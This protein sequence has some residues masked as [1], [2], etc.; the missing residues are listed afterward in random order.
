MADQHIFEYHFFSPRK[1]CTIRYGITSGSRV[2]ASAVLLL[3]QGRAE[4]IEKYQGIARQ[5]QSKGFTV[6][7]FD[8]QGQGLSSRTLE[9][10][11]KGYIQRFDAYVA[12]LEIFYSRVVEP[13]GLP[14]YILAHSMGGHIAL[15]F[16]GRHPSTI[17]KAVLASPMIDLELPVITRQVARFISRRFSGT[18]F[19]EKYVPGS[20]DYSHRQARFKENVLTHDPEKYKILHDEIKKNPDLALGGVT[21]GWLHAAFESIRELKQDKMVRNILVPIL[22][23][24]AQ[25]DRVV[26][27]R[28]Q[29]EFCKRLPDAEFLPIEGAFHELLFEAPAI[30]R[31]V[32]KAFDRFIFG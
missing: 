1:D 8:W 23:I 24:S 19:A 26:S 13:E 17:K 27:S 29:E 3:L 14:V 25:K 30:D 12:D 11:H 4:F 16:M 32:W 20:M 18:G 9:N 7:S 21:W 10:R 15:R 28:A 6:I 31:Q 22:M 2:R 5:L